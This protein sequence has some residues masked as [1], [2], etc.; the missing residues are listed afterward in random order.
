MTQRT[1]VDVATEVRNFIV[2]RFLFGQDGDSLA[3]SASFLEGGIVDSTGVLEIVMFLEQRFGIK[4][5]DEE[6]VPDN[7]DS[8]DKVAAFVARKLA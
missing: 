5:N 3:N 6:L 1:T 2:E 4:V 8:I 7:L